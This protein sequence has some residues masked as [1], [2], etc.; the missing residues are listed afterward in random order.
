[1][2]KAEEYRA[3]A[4]E[5]RLSRRGRERCDRQ[6]QLPGH[7]RAVAPDGCANGGIAIRGGV[8]KLGNSELSRFRSVKHF[9]WTRRGVPAG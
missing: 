3:R 6:G 5:M 2:T 8:K 1:M 7:G 9:A 4:T